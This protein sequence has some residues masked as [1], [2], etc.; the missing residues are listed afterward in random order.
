MRIAVTGGRGFIGERL[1]ARLVARGNNVRVL[2]R[3][4]PGKSWSNVETFSG[5][6]TDPDTNLAKFLRG[7][8]VVFNCAGEF[9]N[10]ELMRAVNVVGTERLIAAA[11]GQIEK[12]IQLS[13]V[14]AYGPVDSGVVTEEWPDAPLG[15]YEVT[16]TEADQ[17]VMTAAGAGAFRSTIVRPSNVYGPTMR[18]RSLFQL[19]RTIQRGQ[20]FFIGQPGA[21]TNYVHVDNVVDALIR[22]AASPKADTRVY[23][24]SDHLGLEDFIGIIAERLDRAAPRVRIPSWVARGVAFAGGWFPGFPL[25][26]SRIRALTGRAV[27]STHRIEA[28]LGYKPVVSMEE[29]L[30][31]MVD[32]LRAENRHGD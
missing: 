7:I 13:S 32:A 4:Q 5:D 29:G 14:G 11:D 19:I 8:D 3:M 12:W 17:R 30:R 21:T 9:R 2:T 16:K 26:A 22:S 15:E 10:P 25:T 24:V 27:Y 23:I 6:L 20:F 31:Q 1:V 28:E 18:N